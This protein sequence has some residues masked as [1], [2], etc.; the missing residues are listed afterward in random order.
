[1]DLP[2]E[3]MLKI[4][5]QGLVVEG[6]IEFCPEPFYLHRH[7][8]DPHVH[9][10]VK[11][12][13]QTARHYHDQRYQEKVLAHNQ[14]MRV[15]KRVYKD[16][17]SVF[18][19]GNEFRFSNSS[20]WFALDRFLYKLGMERANLL[21]QITV[22][23]PDFTVLPTSLSLE[24]HFWDAMIS[25]LGNL[26]G[27]RLATFFQQSRWFDAQM[28]TPDPVLV[29]EKTKTLRNLR[30]LLPP[31]CGDV[32]NCP[33][34]V[35]A[36][37]NLRVTFAAREIPKLFPNHLQ[38]VDGVEMPPARPDDEKTWAERTVEDAHNKAWRAELVCM[39]ELGRYDAIGAGTAGNEETVADEVGEVEEQLR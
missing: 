31:T 24:R 35:D 32:V 15:S 5:E 39:N 11:A 14:L 29:L 13:F 18:F 6:G 4:Y 9:A 23:H 2:N 1:M 21:R 7:A 25:R 33:V 19:G 12:G 37:H 36:F 28:I 20:G 8:A 26:A 22:V 38:I 34:D 10:A 27:D 30:L 16:A 3:L 17:S